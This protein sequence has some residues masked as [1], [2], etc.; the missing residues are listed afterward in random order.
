MVWSCEHAARV[1]SVLHYCSNELDHNCATTSNQ[2]KRT[3]VPRFIQRS[4]RAVSR[5][6]RDKRTLNE[7]SIVVLA[8]DY[9]YLDHKKSH[10]VKSDVKP[11]NIPVGKLANQL[12]LISL[13]TTSAREGGKR[14]KKT[15]DLS[16]SRLPAGGVKTPRFACSALCMYAHNRNPRHAAARSADTVQSTMH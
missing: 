1:F 7:S 12:L 14:A 6:C 8:Q 10:S 13:D 3:R 5:I 16:V 11:S 4:R 9:L 15:T 2:I